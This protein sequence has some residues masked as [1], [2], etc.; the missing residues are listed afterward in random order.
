MFFQHLSFTFFGDV[1]DFQYYFGMFFCP[2]TLLGVYSEYFDFSILQKIYLQ[3]DDV[4]E[5]FK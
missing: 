5:Y 1:F 4:L 3:I 2:N